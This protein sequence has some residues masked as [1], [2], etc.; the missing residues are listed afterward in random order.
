MYIKNIF[1]KRG[2]MTNEYIHKF[3]THGTSQWLADT[4]G[5][6]LNTPKQIHL[7]TVELL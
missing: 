4:P 1:I 3:F 5:F 6:T 7:N 2:D